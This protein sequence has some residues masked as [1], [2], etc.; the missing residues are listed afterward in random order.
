MVTFRGKAVL[1]VDIE[2]SALEQ[3]SYP[4]EIGWA[5]AGL[6]ECE[7]FLIKPTHEWLYNGIWSEESGE[8]HGITRKRLLSEGLDVLD[9]VKRLG[10]A[11][12]EKL[13][14]TDAVQWDSFWLHQLYDAVA[15]PCPFD[16]KPLDT[17]VG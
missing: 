6:L 16:L 9:A 5:P 8:L 10:L 3:G 12:S 13:L 15:R 14:A 4:I 2:A 7:G 1:F 11:F 17:V